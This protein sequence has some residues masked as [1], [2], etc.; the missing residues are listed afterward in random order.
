MSKSPLES[1]MDVV[2]PE[3][4]QEDGRWSLAALAAEEKETVDNRSAL[5]S[6]WSCCCLVRSAR[7]VAEARSILDLKLSSDPLSEICDF[8]ED[9]VEA[10]SG[11]IMSDEAMLLPLDLFFFF[12]TPFL[13]FR[14]VL[15][16]VVS[17]VFRWVA[18]SA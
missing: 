10:L 5:E 1:W 11:E 3:L 2:A 16:T 18:Y 14:L 13:D 12:L 6:D 4:V 8:D 17:A 7:S 15:G 9:V